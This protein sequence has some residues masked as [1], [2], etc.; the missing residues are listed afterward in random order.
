MAIKSVIFHDLCDYDKLCLTLKE[1]SSLRFFDNG[2]LRKM[3]GLNTVTRYRT[4][5]QDEEVQDFSHQ[6]ILE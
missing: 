1:E 3:D 5:L 4:K 6:I 2:T